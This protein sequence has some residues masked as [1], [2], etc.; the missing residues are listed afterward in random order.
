MVKAIR[1]INRDNA[2]VLSSFYNLFC[3]EDVNKVLVES[4]ATGK[5]Y[6]VDGIVV[7]GE[8]QILQIIDKPDVSNGPYF[9]DSVHISPANIDDNAKNQ[10]IIATK[11][12]VAA[13]G[14]VNG[15]FHLEA[16]IDQDIVNVIEIGAR[17][18]FPR[19]LKL[20]TGL[21]IV[22]LTI[23]QHFKAKLAD[24]IGPTCFA[25]NLCINPET[26][27]FFNGISNLET[28]R[29]LPNV[30]EIVVFVQPGD[31][32]HPPPDSSGY[33]GFAIVKGNSYDEVATTLY[34]IRDTIQIDIKQRR[35]DCDAKNNN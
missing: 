21:D 14:L 19:L 25:G 22:K 7:D 16:R 35:I 2:F 12:S 8:A 32:V 33:I 3:P 1:R 31:K 9:P 4:F 13:V 20:S 11:S 23:E 17:I 18:G 27:G 29:K 30:D 24:T 26:A 15:P 6:A 5:E 28:L 34:E 10:L